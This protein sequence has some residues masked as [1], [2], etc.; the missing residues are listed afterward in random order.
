MSHDVAYVAL[1]ASRVAEK[2]AGRADAPLSFYSRS[3]KGLLLLH[4]L[5][6]G[7]IPYLAGFLAIF[8]IRRSRARAS[9]CGRSKRNCNSQGEDGNQS[10]H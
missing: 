1:I 9:K 4:A 6:A 2:G 10:F 7:V 3:A 5:F 8:F